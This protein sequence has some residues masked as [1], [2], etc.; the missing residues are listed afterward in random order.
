MES[1]LHMFIRIVR[2]PT[3][4]QCILH[5]L[6]QFPVT[7]LNKSE[8]RRDRHEIKRKVKAVKYDMKA[9]F[10]RNLLRATFIQ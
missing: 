8:I 4:Y 1:L 5:W 6:I 9:E 10:H 3:A 2:Q 7:A